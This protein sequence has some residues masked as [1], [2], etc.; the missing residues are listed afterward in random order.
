MHQNIHGRHYSAVTF[1]IERM[2]WEEM[3]LGYRS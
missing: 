2:L 3:K 1:S